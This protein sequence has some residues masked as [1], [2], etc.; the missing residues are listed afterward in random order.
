MAFSNYVPPL[1]NREQSGGMPD[2]IG[3]LLGGY[4][5]G[6]QARYLQPGLEEELK[7]AQL[8]NQFFPREKES[9]IGLRQA[10][11][12]LTNTQQE[13]YPRNMQSQ[14][15]LQN[16][17]MQQA[18]AHTG[19]FGE[20]AN[21]NRIK[22][23]QEQMFLDMLRQRLSGESPEALEGQGMG[24]PREMQTPTQ[25]PFA[26]PEQKGGEPL[27]QAIG[28]LMKAPQ[29]T[30]EDFGNQKLFG[31][32]TFTPKYKAYVDMVSKTMQK[33]QA[34]DFKLA[35]QK[36]LIDYKSIEDA[37]LSIPALQ[38]GLNAV[39]EMTRLIKENPGISGHW[40]APEYAEK[41]SEL[42]GMGKFLSKLV[43]I[44]GEVEK[45]LSQRGSQFALKISEK[46]LP[47]VAYS[48]QVNLGKLE[49]LK[50]EFETRIKNAQ[51][52]AGGEIVKRGTKRFRNVNGEWF[53][54]E[55]GDY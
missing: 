36:A 43:P 11:T 2:L 27:Q 46:K 49:G 54:L 47:G 34:A 44:M 20:Q 26:P 25:V 5:Q 52:I 50:E 17:Q 6:T 16:A 45:E 48:Q 51:G 21:E 15:A 8:Y 1:L 42:R 35:S 18:Q 3:Q 55:E 32:D 13:W 40:F 12:G 41:T 28:D 37:Q 31:V 39:E 53:E 30:L 7:K 23:Q 29:P 4:A 33:K 14:L 10:Q 9:E 19:L 22:Q 38:K 24:G